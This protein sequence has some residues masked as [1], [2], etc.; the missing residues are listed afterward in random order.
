MRFSQPLVPGVLLRREK[1]FLVHVRLDDGTEVIAHTNN[2]GTMLGCNTPGSRVWLSP[3]VSPKR[4]LP[5]T[6][7]LIESGQPPVLVGINTILANRIVREAIEADRVESLCNHDWIRSEVSTG[8]G[9]RIDLLLGSGDRDD[10][11]TRTWVE[12]KN[13]TLV[14]D[15]RALFPD[16]VT[17]RGRKHLIELAD[18]ARAGDR[19]VMFYLVQRGDGS[20]FAPAAG[21]DPAY[22][23]ELHRA[24]RAGVQVLAYRARIS[25]TQI[26]VDQRLPLDF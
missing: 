16:A 25:T 23:A 22:A 8:R 6:C 3:A 20:T 21:I 13:V 26:E 15:G 14:E 2:T 12:V 24:R 19:S 7:E 5:W 9:S 17:D 4:K 11:D 10:P 1:R 18:L